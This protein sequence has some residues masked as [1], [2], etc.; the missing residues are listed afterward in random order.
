MKIAGCIIQKKGIISYSEHLFEARYKKRYI[1]I[2]DD[3]GFGHAVSRDLIRYNIEVWGDDGLYD[4][5]TV[6]D[7]P[8]I[9]DAIKY[10]L[11]GACLTPSHRNNRSL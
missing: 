3:H 10:A 9:E 2:S 8:T 6:K 5:D 4:V 11:Q 7:F 1:Y